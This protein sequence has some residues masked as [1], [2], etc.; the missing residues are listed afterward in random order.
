MDVRQLNQLSGIV[1]DSAMHVHSALGPGLLESA[2]QV[3]L[4]HELCD[5]GLRVKSE[6]M[7]PIYYKGIRIDT[8]YRIDVLVEDEIVVELKSVVKLADVHHSQ[9][10]S[11]LRL[12]HR[13]LGLLINF[14]VAHL[15][16]GIKRIVNNLD[17]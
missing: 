9:L 16:D 10:L 6:V 12:G 1:V 15:K 4:V 14:N 11:Q 5:R 13:R 3:C 2:Y 8:A 7:Q 17:E